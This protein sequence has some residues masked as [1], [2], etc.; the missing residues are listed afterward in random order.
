MKSFFYLS[1][2]L[3]F[4]G[5]ATKAP[6]PLAPKIPEVEFK[7]PVSQSIDI[8]GLQNY[9]GLRR[10]P[11]ALGFK[12][13]SFQTCKVGNGYPNDHHCQ[14]KHFIV[15]HFQLMCRD[16]EGTIS[17]ILTSADLQPLSRRP[18]I[19]TLKDHS[20]TLQTD[21]MGYGQI[22]VISS[23]SQSQQRLKLSTGNDFLYMRAGEITRVAIPPSW[24]ESLTSANK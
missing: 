12:E 11:T 6:S 2:L 17:T 5:C 23:S 7:S 4:F 1:T 3:F 8:V 20:S 9:L 16:S 18:V 15:I 24:C 22:A 21:E 13:K 19:W 10:P 14:T